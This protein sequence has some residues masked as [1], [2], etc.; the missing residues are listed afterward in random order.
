MLSNSLETIKA[1]AAKKDLEKTRFVVNIYFFVDGHDYSLELYD[2]P[3]NVAFIQTEAK[4]MRASINTE[5]RNV[6][7]AMTDSDIASAFNKT[8]KAD[9][10]QALYTQ[11]ILF[12]NQR[13]EKMRSLSGYLFPESEAE[14]DDNNLN[15][16]LELNDD[17]LKSEG[18]L[19]EKLAEGDIEIL[20]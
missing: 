2:G 20:F 7:S 15:R 4:K 6:N 12:H 18:L 3:S 11:T 13:L 9:S 1:F 19:N 14:V 16:G 10:F 17:L 5:V 8:A